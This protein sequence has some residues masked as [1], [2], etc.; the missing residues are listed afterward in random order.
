MEIISTIV[1]R[2]SQ[3]GNDPANSLHAAK[4]ITTDRNFYKLEDHG[5]RMADSPRKKF[6]LTYY[7]LSNTTY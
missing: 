4:Q 1:D 5:A 7:S 2:T 6:N 3:S